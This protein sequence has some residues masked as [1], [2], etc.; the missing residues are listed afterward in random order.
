MI[1]RSILYIREV[2]FVIKLINTVL[3]FFVICPLIALAGLK[4]HINCLCDYI[5]ILFFWWLLD[6]E[7]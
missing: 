6:F 7:S 4:L 1:C 3:N 5:I 2:D